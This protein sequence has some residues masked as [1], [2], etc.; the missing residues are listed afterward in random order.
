MVIVGR[1]GATVLVWASTQ[2]VGPLRTRVK[3]VSTY[4]L[5]RVLTT[6]VSH[7]SK[8]LRNILPVNV[9]YA[10]KSKVVKLLCVTDYDVLSIFTKFLVSIICSFLVQFIITD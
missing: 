6:A 7:P 5:V 9:E 10:A 8:L 1:T 4:L 2:T 3:S